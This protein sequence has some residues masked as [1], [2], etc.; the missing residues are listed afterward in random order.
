MTT[1]MMISGDIG[2]RVTQLM[3]KEAM[4]GTDVVRSK[5]FSDDD[6]A[7]RDMTIY[8]RGKELSTVQ[9]KCITM[10]GGPNRTVGQRRAV[11]DLEFVI[12]Y[13]P[14]TINHALHQTWIT[15]TYLAARSPY[16]RDLAKHHLLDLGLAAE[17]IYDYEISENEPIL[18]WARQVDETFVELV[19]KL[20]TDEDYR[21]EYGSSN[22]S[23][24]EIPTYHLARPYAVLYPLREDVEP[25]FVKL[26]TRAWK[27][28][29][30]K[31]V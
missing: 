16:Y 21:R 9:A 27:G 19:Q 25:Q 24:L 7:G 20:H 26:R 23:Q 6:F 1:P 31:M 4:P 22:A 10:T 11:R 14:Y 18:W 29:S 30:S 28:R 13:S 5:A 2:E 17:Q 3:L 15:M 8:L 12:K